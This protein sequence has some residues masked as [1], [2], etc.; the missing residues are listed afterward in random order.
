MFRFREMQRSNVSADEFTM[1]SVRDHS[2]CAARCF[3]DGRMGES[4]H[5]QARD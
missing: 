4:L 1:V 2:L 3:G 5:Q